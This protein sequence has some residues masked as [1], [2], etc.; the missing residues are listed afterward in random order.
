LEAKLLPFRIPIR[1]L[2]MAP[3]GK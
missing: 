2:G 3:G 1:V